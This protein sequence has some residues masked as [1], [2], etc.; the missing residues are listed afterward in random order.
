MQKLSVLSNVVL[1]KNIIH[2]FHV[3]ITVVF[4]SLSRNPWDYLSHKVLQLKGKY[5]GRVRR[6]ELNTLLAFLFTHK[7][8]K[9][10]QQSLFQ[11]IAVKL[12]WKLVFNYT[13]IKS[14][15]IF[16]QLQSH[17]F[18]IY[19]WNNNTNKGIKFRIQEPFQRQPPHPLF[20]PIFKSKPNPKKLWR[21]IQIIQVTTEYPGGKCSALASQ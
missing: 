21:T 19:K 20:K 7:S 5:C 9:T 6:A 11:L 10:P 4:N 13:E 15:S 16:C 14:K 17:L 8:K 18:W 1:L 12:N 3:Y 2:F